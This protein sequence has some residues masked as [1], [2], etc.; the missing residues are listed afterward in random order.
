MA[1]RVKEEPI[2]H[3]NRI[4]EQ[5]MILF[6]KKG[7]DNT[8]MDEIASLAGYSKATVYVYFKNKDDIISFLALQSMIKLRTAIETA[9]LKEEDVKES[10]FK[11]CNS[12]VDY[13]RYYPDFFDMSLKHINVKSAEY[14]QWDSQTYKVGEEINQLLYQYLE[15]GIKS[16]IFKNTD[17]SFETVF[18]MWG[19]IS[20]VIALASEKEEYILLAG[21]ITKERFMQD[22]FEK[23]YSS[24]CE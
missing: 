22:G 6:A 24:I 9:V 11:I 1:R 7:I 17:N 4:A 18:L 2:V 15:K 14:N 3:Q 13:H 12:L 5:A 10:F 8:K 16:G 20:G 23:I 19:M 21:K